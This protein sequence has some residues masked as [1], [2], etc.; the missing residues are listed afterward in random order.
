MAH[1]TYS[2]LNVIYFAF[3]LLQSHFY[4]RGLEP[5]IKKKNYEGTKIFFFHY[6][7]WEKT[8]NFEETN[9]KEEF[10]VDILRL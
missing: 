7:R 2:Y 3:I 1:F 4:R 10:K 6:Q 8:Q 5:G 9:K